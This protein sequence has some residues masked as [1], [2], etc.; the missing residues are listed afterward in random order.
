MRI[1][2]AIG[3]GIGILVLQRLAPAIY[4]GLEASLLR[5][6][7]AAGSIFDAAQTVLQKAGL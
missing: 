4:A 6:F 2:R 1:F 7:E 3:L 5:F